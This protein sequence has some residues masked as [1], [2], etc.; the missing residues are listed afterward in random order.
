[1][2]LVQPTKPRLVPASHLRPF[3][4]NRIL[5]DYKKQHGLYWKKIRQIEDFDFSEIDKNFSQQVAEKIITKEEFEPEKNIISGHCSS[6][7]PK[8]SQSIEIFFRSQKISIREICHKVYTMHLD[9]DDDYLIKFL[10]DNHLTTQE[11]ENITLSGTSAPIGE[12]NMLKVY[13]IPLSDLRLR[14]INLP[15]KN[16]SNLYSYKESLWAANDFLSEI[17]SNVF[18]EEFLSMILTSVNYI[19]A[20]NENRNR[21]D[22]FEL[23]LLRRLVSYRSNNK[24]ENLL[25]VV[26]RRYIA[27]NINEIHS[28]HLYPPYPDPKNTSLLE[29][30]AFAPILEGLNEIKSNI[31]ELQELVNQLYRNG[32]SSKVQTG[33]ID[34]T[35]EA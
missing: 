25:E 18:I 14:I 3:F 5:I 27:V 31:N 12:Q 29:G 24:N 19:N 34:N 4:L 28:L 15:F 6:L 26:V 32:K 17:S 23:D 2:Y 11:A 13:K 21:A 10:Q 16:I 33:T 20:N 8:K 7:P 35:Y 22:G 1:M 9:I 30:F